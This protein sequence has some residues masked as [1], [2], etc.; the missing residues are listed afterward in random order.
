MALQTEAARPTLEQR[1]GEMA[2]IFREILNYDTYQGK[3]FIPVEVPIKGTKGKGIDKYYPPIF[4]ESEE[5]YEQA[6]VVHHRQFPTDIIGH[7]DPK[8]GYSIMVWL[9]NLNSRKPDGTF[10][11]PNFIK[12]AE[13]TPP[14]DS[15]GPLQYTEF[16]LESG[17]PILRQITQGG[18]IGTISEFMTLMQGEMRTD[19]SSVDLSRAKLDGSMWVKSVGEGSAEVHEANNFYKLFDKLLEREA[20]NF[21][22]GYIDQL[23]RREVIDLSRHALAQPLVLEN[24]NPLSEGEYQGYTLPVVPISRHKGENTVQLVQITKSPED[25][26]IEPGLHLIVRS[27]PKL[28]TPKEI[29]IEGLGVSRLPGFVSQAPLNNEIFNVTDV[30]TGGGDRYVVLQGNKRLSDPYPGTQRAHKERVPLF[31]LSRLNGYMNDMLVSTRL[32]APFKS[33]ADIIRDIRLP[34]P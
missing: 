2:K 29:P 28:L 4:V 13:F 33:M 30:L 17:K 19:G 15:K 1:K 24:I 5:D 18:M 22:E 20:Q 21:P 32:A 6:F 14:E 11:A 34:K 8:T 27:F 9:Q 23:E 25:E 26:P 10:A 12:F 7:K 16:D 31:V 3:P